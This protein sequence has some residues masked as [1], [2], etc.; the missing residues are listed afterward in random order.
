MTTDRVPKLAAYAFYHGERSTSWA[1]S[2]K[3]R[4]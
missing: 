4:E 2:P 1:A 3:A